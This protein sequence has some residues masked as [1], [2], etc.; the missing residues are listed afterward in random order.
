M[1]ASPSPTAIARA[2]AA[3]SAQAGAA[4]VPSTA[5]SAMRA[6]RSMSRRITFSLLLGFVF[7]A[8]VFRNVRRPRLGLDR[9]RRLPHHVELAVRLDLADEDGLVQVMVLHVHRRHET[10]RRLE[11]LAGHRRDHLVGVGGLGL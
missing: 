8:L 10:A 9:A 1:R 5:A 6:R 4:T 11:G 7:L 2:W 3:S